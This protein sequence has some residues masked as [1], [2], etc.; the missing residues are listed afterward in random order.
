MMNEEIFLEMQDIQKS[1]GIVSVLKGVDL[2][3]RKGEVHALVGENGAGKSTLIKIL[4]G[5]Y[6]KNSGNI[7]V[8][9]ENVE[10]NSQS[11]S[12]KLGISTIYQELSMIPTLTVAQNIMLGK[13]KSTFGVLKQKKMYAEVQELIDY[14]GFKLKPDTVVE[15]LSIAQQQMVE[16]LKALNSDASMLVMDEPTAS[17]SGE[18]SELLFN[19]IRKLKTKGV[20][21]LYI[22]HRLE[23]VFML[24]DTISVLRNGTNIA[25]IKHDDVV[26]DEII[27]LMI[28]KEFDDS[29]TPSVLHKTDSPVILS[30]DKLCRN[31]VFEDISF[32]LHQGEILGIGGLVGSGRT[33]I[34][35]NIFG[36]DKY[37]SGEIL[38]EGKKI[39]N[40]INYMIDSG[41]GLVPENRRDEGLFPLLSITENST[42]PSLDDL[43]NGMYL[44]R[45]KVSDFGKHTIDIL[46][47]RPSN[48]K[49]VV[50]N[51][52]GGNQQKIVLGKWLL[53][54]LKVLLIDELTAGVDIG[55]KSE[56]Y[57]KLKELAKKGLSVIIVSS[58]MQELLHVSDR[59]L[60]VRNGK[61]VKEFDDGVVSQ[62]TILSTSSGLTNK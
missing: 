59:I 17:L 48:P 58:D 14:Y 56:I 4:T 62:E 30:V 6:S 53:R 26:P 42:V 52:S 22:S 39:P 50:G 13:E 41:F 31:N 10:I 44:S 5:I 21:V 29:F 51:M 36:I 28:G 43:S 3:I 12:R 34:L 7:L 55:A 25:S 33:E 32:D 45:K 9:G 46:D 35:Q 54:D 16:I 37:D 24:S 19:I 11:D 40:S 2:K 57:G 60:I 15:T 47:V 27:E 1:F 61:I 8:N 38:F 49:F 20:S 18:E 23:E